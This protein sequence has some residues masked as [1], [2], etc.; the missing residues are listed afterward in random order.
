MKIEDLVET[1]TKHEVEARRQKEEAII[2]WKNE[3]SSDK[4]PESFKDEFCLPEALKVICQEL[5]NVKRLLED[6]QIRLFLTQSATYLA[7][8][9]N[10]DKANT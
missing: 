10:S 8:E 2:R 5:L 3:F 9:E 1:F 7:P 6:A 4:I